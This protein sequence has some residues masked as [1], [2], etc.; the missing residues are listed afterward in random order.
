MNHSIEHS[1]GPILK[2][3]GAVVVIG[4]VIWI[5]VANSESDKATIQQWADNNN[6]VKVVSVESTWIDK[7]PYWVKE[8]HHRIYKVVVIDH[9]EKQRTTYFRFGGWF[10][11]EQDWYD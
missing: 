5:A 10:G 11:Y 3:F 1:F 2:L 4:L 8:D 9:L 6:I 7:G